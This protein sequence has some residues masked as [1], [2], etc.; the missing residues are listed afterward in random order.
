M[1]ANVI[2]MELYY[3][4]QNRM[5][6]FNIIYGERIKNTMGEQYLLNMDIF[7][8]LRDTWEEIAHDETGD[9]NIDNLPADHHISEESLNKLIEQGITKVYNHLAYV[10]E[11]AKL[12][13]IEIDKYGK[14]SV[15]YTYLAGEIVEIGVLALN[16]YTNVY[17]QLNEI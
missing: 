1:P 4:L 7:Q 10:A 12:G 9:Y 13:E 5:N 11:N 2:N 16:V 15:D 14:E 17:K 8:D 3:A 6:R